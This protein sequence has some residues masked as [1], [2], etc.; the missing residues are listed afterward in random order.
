MVN[1]NPVNNI[2]PLGLKCIKSLSVIFAST[3]GGNQQ[4]LQNHKGGY[5][6]KS[7]RVYYGTLT[8]T[9]DD[10][11]TQGWSVQAG[12]YRTDSSSV[13]SGDDSSTPAGSFTVGTTQGGSHN[14]FYINGT[15][16]D[17]IMI[18]D[19]EGN[20]GTHGCVG[21]TSSFTTFADDMKTTKNCCKKPSLPISITYNVSD[22]DA[23]KGDKGH[24][25]SSPYGPPIEPDPGPTQ[26]GDPY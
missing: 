11:S 2:D 19:S 7:G 26:S 16:R 18:H 3:N 21:V 9:Y 24:G 8:A 15:G 23:P 17:A 4:D 14:G 6:Y 5:N 1:N 22:N 12:G 20:A 13:N 25:K 10:S